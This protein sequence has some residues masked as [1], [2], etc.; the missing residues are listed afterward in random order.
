[1]TA[2]VIV[3]GVPSVPFRKRTG[4][5]YFKYTLYFATKFAVFKS[6]PALY[7]EFQYQI[8]MYLKKGHL[9]ENGIQPSQNHFMSTACRVKLLD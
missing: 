2:H 9:A 4:L 6:S 1:M 5:F 3:Q 7:L 8:L